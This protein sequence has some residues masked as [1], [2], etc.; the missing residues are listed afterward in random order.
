MGAGPE[1]DMKTTS[2][3]ATLLVVLVL[4]GSLIGC[5]AAADPAAGVQETFDQAMAFHE[6]GE[7]EKVWTL[8]SIEFR[9]EITRGFEKQKDTVRGE[10]AKNSDWI[11][12]WVWKQTQLT[13]SQFL[14]LSPKEID[15]RANQAQRGDILR[16]RIVGKIIVEGEIAHAKVTRPPGN[17]EVPV[18][19]V[20]RDGRWLFHG[21]EFKAQ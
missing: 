11:E 7:H 1:A 3:I 9:E 19:F 2:T 15:A 21:R 5:P 13:P 17:I 14:A 18:R 20:L 12:E 4:A 6:A 10:L 8:Y 16:S